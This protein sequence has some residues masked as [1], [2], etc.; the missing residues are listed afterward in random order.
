MPRHFIAQLKYGNLK[1][2]IHC[3]DDQP[4]G[5]GEGGGS[6]GV[7]VAALQSEL[8]QLREQIDGQKN[9]IQTLR[10]FER[11]YKT[12][13]GVLGDLDP[14][15]LENLKRTDERLAQQQQHQEQQALEIRQQVA[16]EYDPK[17][18]ALNKEKQTLQ[19]E[20]GAVNLTFDLFRD[21]NANGGIG[22]R[23]QSFMKIAGGNFER[24]QEGGIQVRDDAG[25]LVI[26]KDPDTKPGESSERVAT[27]ADFL[28]MLANGDVAKGS[29]RFNELEMLSLTLEAAN[30]SSGAG[31]PTNSGYNTSKPLQDLSQNELG[32]MAF[33]A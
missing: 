1:P 18:Q 24:N 8:A 30:K 21:F 15:R 17:I 19:D 2:W 33:P 29:Y 12:V 26:Y 4:P 3:I 6:G 10:G 5:E 11:Q 31:L 28:K 25:N 22:S 13:S 9:L 14:E 23:F 20:L 27:P 16:S 32:K 7:N